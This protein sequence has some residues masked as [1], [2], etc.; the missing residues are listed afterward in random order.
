VFIQRFTNAERILFFS[1]YLD[2]TKSEAQRKNVFAF[3]QYLVYLDI[4]NLDDASIVAGTQY[5]ETVAVLAAGRA[6]QILS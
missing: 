5:L 2:S 4:I 1:Y 3:E 6:A